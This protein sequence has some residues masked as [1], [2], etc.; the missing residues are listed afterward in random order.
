LSEAPSF[1]QPIFTY[2]PHGAG[3]TAYRSLAKE[4]A[5]RFDLRENAAG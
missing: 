5:D 4:V 3:A 2:D 1:G